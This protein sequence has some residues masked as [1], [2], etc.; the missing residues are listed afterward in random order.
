MQV[1]R[2]LSRYADYGGSGKK[3][4]HIPRSRHVAVTGKSRKKCKIYI[5]FMNGSIS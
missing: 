4:S 3:N 1:Q 2:N 5:I